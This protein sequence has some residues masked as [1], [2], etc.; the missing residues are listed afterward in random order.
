MFNR[1]KKILGRFPGLKKAYSKFQWKK[2]V[3]SDWLNTK[4]KKEIQINTPYG[5]SLVARNYVAN[6]MMLHGVFETEEVDLMKKYLQLCDRFIDIGANIGFYSCIARSMGRPVTAFE[7]QPH[8]LEYF[9]QNM[10]N[11][12]WENTEIFP[13]G[14]S[15]RRDL[16][17]LYGASGPSASLLKGW[18]GYS[19]STRQIIPVAT[20]DSV[21]GDSYSDQ[22]LLIKIDVE[23]AE[24]DVL[25]GAIKT[26]HRKPRPV[27]FMEIC[28]SEFHPGEVNQNYLK[29]FD[30]FF[31]QGYEVR[32]A[33]LA[34]SA[35]RREDVVRWIEQGHTD[36][37]NFN[38]LFIP[39][40]LSINESF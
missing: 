23:G 36:T 16:L 29:T 34:F 37:G 15:N 27:W 13:I 18:A 31:E 11:N 19:A 4:L 14:L 7:P 26:L 24:F 38:Y 1:L 21:L 25:Q 22:R 8:N 30:Y 5:F 10:L 17:V 9:Y 20:L 3:W 12:K 35:V 6:R 28:L 33:N 40:D 32:T 39:K 2:F